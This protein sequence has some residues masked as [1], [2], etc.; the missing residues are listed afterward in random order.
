MTEFASR[1]PDVRLWAINRVKARI[2]DS[3]ASA[4]RQTTLA[5]QV[6]VSVNPQQIETPVSRIYFVSVE[7]FD[8]T[9]KA[10]ALKLS[11]DAAY[12]IES[13]PR[14]G[15]PVVRA[16]LNAGPNEFRDSASGEYS[17][18]TVVLIVVAR[19]P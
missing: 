6:V 4:E 16:A 11:A 18:E 2:A 17:Y 12:E 14:D 19:L 10:A 3:T 9:S 15:S 7:A 1:W 13:A 5:R 8:A